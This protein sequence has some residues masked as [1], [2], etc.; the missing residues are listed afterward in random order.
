MVAPDAAIPAKAVVELAPA[1]AA[2]AA[3]ALEGLLRTVEGGFGGGGAGIVAIKLASR[4]SW[5]AF[6]ILSRPVE[7]CERR[8]RRGIV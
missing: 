1:R 5:D 2:A 8:W 3:V 7:G 6:A 4:R